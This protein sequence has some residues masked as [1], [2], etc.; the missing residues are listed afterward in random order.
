MTL[1]EIEAAPIILDKDVYDQTVNSRTMRLQND[2][3]VYILF[4]V[5]T[6]DVGLTITPQLFAEFVSGMKPIR[7]DIMPPINTTGLYVMLYGIGSSPDLGV[8]HHSRSI[9]LPSLLAVRFN[10]AG[11]GSYEGLAG[12][13]PLA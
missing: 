1:L 3:Y 4:R 9:A 10:L 11:T 13:L 8:L 12:Y 2:K 6:I 7:I 5:S